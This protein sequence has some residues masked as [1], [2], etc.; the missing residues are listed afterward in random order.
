MRQ[1]L[2]LCPTYLKIQHSIN[3]NIQSITFYIL[4]V[5]Y[6]F[7]KSAP[8]SILVLTLSKCRMNPIGHRFWVRYL[9][10]NNVFMF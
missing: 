6:F 4:M 2:I 8:P 7:E 1:E 5:H 3:F 9:T 10:S